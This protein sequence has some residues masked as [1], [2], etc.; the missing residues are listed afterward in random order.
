MQNEFG[1]WNPGLTSD[2]PAHLKP[3]ITLY[4]DENAT[5]TYADAQ[6]AADFCGLPVRQ[7]YALRPERLLKH[8]LLIRVTADLSVPDGT[9]YEVLGRNLRGMT[10]TIYDTYVVPELPHLQEVFAA[11]RAEGA[12]LIEARLAND[13]F[14]APPPPPSPGI[15]DRLRGRKP[16][17]PPP[18]DP[19]AVLARWKED[20]AA[21]G[22]ATG[23]ALSSLVTI[24]SAILAHRGRLVADQALIA[25][26]ALT[27]F[28]NSHGS[29]ALGQA[30]TPIFKRAVAAEN[31]RFLP[32]QDA[33]VILNV[34]GASASG[35]STIRPQQRR[36]AEKLDLPWEDFALI[37]PD[38][39][40][41]YLLDYE[42]LGPDYKYG[43][44][45]TGHE[46]EIIDRKLD[47][48]VEG[49]AEAGNIPH[50]LVDRFRFDSF[51]AGADG[52][53]SN[54]LLTRFGDRV[55]LFFMVTS[56]AETVVRAWRR[57]Q[58]T[59]RYKAVDDLLHHNVE[60]Y[61]G[62]PHLFFSWL[63]ADDKAIHFEFLDNDVPL[64]ELPRTI[65]YGWNDEMVVLRPEGLHNIDR[66]RA[67]N[68]EARG[69]DEVFQ[70]IPAPTPGFLAECLKTIP[71][72][73]FADPGRE[74]VFARHESS[75]WSQRDSQAKLDPALETWLDAQ[76]WADAPDT[77]AE[78]LGDAG[79]GRPAYRLGG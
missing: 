50:L 71:T 77:G 67:V 29:R 49:K 58:D 18:P 32:A 70:G 8:E 19:G 61:T 3:L 9:S 40:R 7:M 16:E 5:R 56:P 36:L 21:A 37:S 26:L 22:P 41:K 31:Y 24:L 47:D 53:M 23:A 46:L 38:Y 73:S 27:V 25:R 59:G 69:P 68:L 2:I 48:Y 55:F 34:K 28:C 65:A 75:G 14:A 63:K 62:M 54:R 45:L 78:A 11:A 1:P 33:P 52:K 17:A 43:A 72:V 6:E 20:A 30:L 74:E 76:G 44:M 10:A 60:A 57:G 13:L 66:F 64:G 15:L 51:T 42:S 35:K 12:A 79:H 39:W 4:R